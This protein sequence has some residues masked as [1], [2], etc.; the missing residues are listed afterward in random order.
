MNG[1]RMKNASAYS[2]VQI[3]RI[4]GIFSYRQLTWSAYFRMK[5][6]LH[7]VITIF[8]H[9]MICI[10]QMKQCNNSHVGATLYDREI[11]SFSPKTEIFLIYA[12]LPS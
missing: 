2:A 11:P 6:R 10:C 1:L 7:K 12:M 9:A 4:F 8:C 5:M 3:E